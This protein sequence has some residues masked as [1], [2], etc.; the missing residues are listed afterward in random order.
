[1]LSLVGM[2][3]FTHHETLKREMQFPAGAAIP[4]TAGARL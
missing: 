3:A 1:M 2:A 4:S